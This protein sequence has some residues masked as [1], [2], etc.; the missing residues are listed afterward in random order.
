M[1]NILTI[2]IALCATLSYSQQSNEENKKNVKT[3]EVD[4]RIELI[5]DKD[6]KEIRLNK[7]GEKE[8]SNEKTKQDNTSDFKLQRNLELGKNKT[9]EVIIKGINTAAITSKIDIRPFVLSS[10][11]PEIIKPI[12]SGITESGEVENLLETLDEI[13]TTNINYHLIQNLKVIY[14]ESLDNY[15]SLMFL[16]EESDEL[17]KKTIYTTDTETAEEKYEDVLKKFVI[18]DN[19]I[20]SLN[21]KVAKYKKYIE[22]SK[23]FFYTNLEKINPPNEELFDLYTQLAFFVEEIEKVDFRK[24]SNFIHKS[25]TSENM[26]KAIKFSPSKDGVDL[27]ILLVNSYSKDTLLKK[28]FQLYSSGGVSFDFTTGFFYSDLVEEAYFLKGREGDSTKTNI[29]KEDTRNFDIAFGALGHIS[30]KFTSSFKAGISMGASLSPLDAKTRYH[31]G[32]SLIFG[33]KNQIAINGGVSFAKIKIL[34]D[35]IEDDVSGIYVPASITAVPT[36]EKIEKGIYFGLTY[37][38]TTNKKYSK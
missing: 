6:K 9:Y 37:N 36:F 25:T 18:T 34:S 33:R 35:S 11:T 26:T 38:L 16:K 12:F 1:R 2:T 4:A 31:V 27:D 32:G 14:K 21:N 22:S 23:K 10:K 29:L 13:D 15:T 24:Y 20:G 30:Y 19:K 5:Y 3:N 28:P 7:I 17:Y 8:N